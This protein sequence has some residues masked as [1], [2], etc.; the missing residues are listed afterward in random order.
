MQRDGAARHVC[1]NQTSIAFG[2]VVS[3]NVLHMSILGVQFFT[4][5]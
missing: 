5:E 1:C 4:D 3:Q 2:V